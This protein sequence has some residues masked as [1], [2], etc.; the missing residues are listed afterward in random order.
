M[1]TRRCIGDYP[2]IGADANGFYLTT[3]EYSF[4]SDGSNGGAGVH[5]RPDL[6]HLQAPTRRRGRPA[7]DRDVREPGARPVPQLHRV[8][9]DRAGGQG[10]DGEN[11]GTEYFLSST[12]GDGSETGNTAPSEKR[13]GVVGDDQHARRWTRRH[14]RLQLANKLDRGGHVRAPA[15]VD[16]EGRADTA[17]AT[18]S[19]TAATLRSAASA[20]GGCCSAAHRDDRRCSAVSTRRHPHAAG[21]LLP[22]GCCGAHSS[23]AVSV[24]SQRGHVQTRAGV[25]WVGVKAEGREGPAQRRDE[26]SGYVASGRQRRQLPG[27]RADVAAARSSWLP[28]SAAPT[29]TR[30]RRTP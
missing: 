23:T 19:T 17:R 30:A 15:E 14:R 13:I 12:L 5:R 8:A 29:T 28:R 27:A 3:N 26:A 24:E 10:L 20:A 6:R 11:G 1:T 2:H 22:T 16:A 25:L 18:A 21:G 9:G 7:D 4:F